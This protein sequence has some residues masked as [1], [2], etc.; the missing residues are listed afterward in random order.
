ML[1]FLRTLRGLLTLAAVFVGPGMA[2]FLYTSELDPN[3]QARVLSSGLLGL[4]SSALVMFLAIKTHELEQA[5]RR[6]RSRPRHRS[7][8]VDWGS[9]ELPSLR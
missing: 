6:P 4:V 3:W 7:G 8:I 2:W 1:L 9:K 5:L